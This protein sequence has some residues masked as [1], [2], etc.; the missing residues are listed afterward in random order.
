[1]PVI[2]RLNG[3]VIKMYFRKKEHNPPHV[4]ALYGEYNGMR[5]EN[6]YDT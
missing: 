1:M 2:T 6:A 5:G 3:I 4:H